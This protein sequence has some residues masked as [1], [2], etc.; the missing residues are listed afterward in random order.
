[1]K[2]I[3]SILL[4]ILVVT[5]VLSTTSCKK[6]KDEIV[7]PLIDYVLTEYNYGEVPVKRVSTDSTA[8]K[9]DAN[10]RL[11]QMVTEYDETTFTYDAAGRVIRIDMPSYQKVTSSEY[12]LLTW[13]GSTVTMQRYWGEEEPS[14]SKKVITFNDN[15]EITLIEYLYNWVPRKQVEDNWVKEG[16]AE[17]EWS[18]GNVTKFSEYWM[19]QYKGGSILSKG[20]DKVFIG[21]DWLFLDE[22]P[23][24]PG[25]AEMTYNLN[26]E[27]LL[28]YDNKLNPFVIYPGLGLL[29]GDEMFHMFLGKNNV[30]KTELTEYWNENSYSWEANATYE[31]NNDNFPIMITI[32]ESDDGGEWFDEEIWTIVYL[33]E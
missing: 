7:I 29:Y 20:T 21:S 12:I 22:D 19:D 6:D 15:D 25:K 17:L 27:A 14:Y 30:V 8:F 2:R 5:M 28:T 32:E 1:M 11:I 23:R 4:P 13:D 18:N 31:Y 33:E 9:Y 10:E 24:E 26:L 3:I 16:Y